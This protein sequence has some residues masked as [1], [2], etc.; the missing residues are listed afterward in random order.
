LNNPDLE[1]DLKNS[2]EIVA[3]CRASDA[4]AQNLYAALCNM[5]WQKNEMF[6]VIKGELWHCSWRYA[7]RIAA[8]L[9]GEGDYLDF[10]CSGMGGFDL[11][12]D[13]EKAAAWMV[14]H[15]YVPEAEVTDEIRTDFAKLG[16][17]PVPYED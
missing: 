1:L 15:Q 5:Q 14:D 10:Y 9:R 6:P 3:K 8:E 7:G 17:Y 4:Y 2:A 13:P 11:E 16:W 12:Y